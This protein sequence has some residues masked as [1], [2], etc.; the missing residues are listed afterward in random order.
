MSDH[1]LDID[2]PRGDVADGS[3]ILDGVSLSVA[4]GEVVGVVGESGSGKSTMALAMLGFAR[5]GAGS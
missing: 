4:R 1:V 5:P 3:R 2:G